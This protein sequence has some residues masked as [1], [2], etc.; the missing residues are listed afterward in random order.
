MEEKLKMT[1]VSDQK[2]ARKVKNGAL[3]GGGSPRNR[4]DGSTRTQILISAMRWFA[5]RGFD[6]ASVTQIASD[7]GVPQPLINYHF[8]NKFKLW[9]A[10]IDFLFD[11]LIRDLDIFSSSLK[12]LEPVDALKVTLRRHVEFVARRPEFF[13]IAIVEAREET[14]RLQ[15][16][17]GN[18]I[19]PLNKV[20]EDLI[21]AAQEKGQVKKAPVLNILEIIIGATII[22]F[23]PSAAFRFSEDFV[24]KGGGVDPEHAD[25]VV[26]VLFGGLAIRS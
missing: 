13:M 19:N 11:E 5:R 25:V 3:D 26:E 8:G 18:Y 16:L 9:Q 7:A 23:G 20:M 12:D 6:G 10:V 4:I 2:V 14:E 15:Y 22:F 1:Q 17:M 21:F 24:T